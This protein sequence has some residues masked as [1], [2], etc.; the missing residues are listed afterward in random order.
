MNTSPYKTE[1]W[2][3]PVGTLIQKKSDLSVYAIVCHSV[4]AKWGDP[5]YTYRS[6]S[7]S[8]YIITQGKYVVENGDFVP[9]TIDHG[10]H[11]AKLSLEER[12]AQ[13]SHYQFGSDP[14]SLWISMICDE[15]LYYKAWHAALAKHLFPG[16]GTG[17]DPEI[18]GC[19]AD[20]LRDLH[21]KVNDVSTT[22]KE[23]V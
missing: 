17:T 10:G 13:L 12:V 5:L 16:V 7:D 15:A 21:R 6:I 8:T 14:Q 18:L 22:T 1:L 9:H 4:D 19:V 11:P 23:E 2:Y 20:T 3:Y